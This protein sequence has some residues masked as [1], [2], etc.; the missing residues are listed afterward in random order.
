MPKPIEFHFDFSSPYSYI[1]SEQIEPLAARHGRTLLK[2]VLRALFSR[3]RRR[4]TDGAIWAEGELRKARL[5]ND[6]ALCGVPYQQPSRFPIG[7]VAAKRSV[8]WLQHIS[9]NSWA[10]IHALYAPFS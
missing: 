1:A 6:R 5:S 2:P 7:S 4:A 9:L 3:L 10:L 8:I